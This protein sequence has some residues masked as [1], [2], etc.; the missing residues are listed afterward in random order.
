MPLTDAEIENLLL[1]KHGPIWR[2]DPLKQSDVH[3]LDGFASNFLGHVK[4]IFANVAAQRA[5]SITTHLMLLEKEDLNAFAGRPGDKNYLICLN[6]GLIRKTRDAF[7]SASGTKLLA[8]HFPKIHTIDPNFLPL[9]ASFLAV[10]FVFFHEYAHV[11]RGH[12]GYLKSVKLNEN[13]VLEAAGSKMSPARI[14]ARYLAECDADTWGGYLV[15]RSV[16]Q[17]VDTVTQ[18]QPAGM[19][20]TLAE[21]VVALA[22][23]AVALLFRVMEST[24]RPTALYPPHIVRSAIVETQ[25]MLGLQEME[26]ASR[27]LGIASISGT[28][29]TGMA[30]GNELA[31]DLA[32]AEAAIDGKAAAEIWVKNDAPAVNALT[33]LLKP[34]LP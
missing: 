7:Y 27:T 15:A 24:G 9:Q 22:G 11:F 5:P 13:E 33:A 16:W 23:F 32:L 2:P 31:K 6:R 18:G 21:E 20:P 26:N 29:V 19:H 34:F 3:S 10:T 14:R 12:L 28:V 25:M 17:T 30:H 1:P 8:K 4:A